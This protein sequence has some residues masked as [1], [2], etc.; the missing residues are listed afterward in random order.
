MAPVA[1]LAQRKHG[2]AGHHFAAVFQ[3]HLNQDFQVA[4]LGLAV[5]QGHHVDAKGV[6]Q[7]RLLVQV[8]EHHLG[9]FATL[10]LNHHPHARLV[11]LVLNVANALNLFLVHQLGNALEQ[12]LFVHLVGDFVDDD[13]L[14]LAFVNVFK[15]ALGAHHHTAAASAVAVFDAG[16]AVNQ[17]ACWKVGRWNNLHQ[18]INAGF[19]L[20]QQVQASV[21]HLVEVVRR[22][23]GG[24]AHRNTARAVDQQVGQA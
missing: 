8:V 7:L 5:N 24:H 22:N 21:Y 20:A 17:A 16:N 4:Q 23:V 14:A 9:H 19:G 15:V 2:A 10:E 1:R 12:A 13:R 11:G 3:K 18:L 6:L